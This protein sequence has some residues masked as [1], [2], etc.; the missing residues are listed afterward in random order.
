MFGREGAVPGHEIIGTVVEAG[1][2]S[3]VEVGT[4]VGAGWQTNSCHACG[5]CR[6]GYEQYCSDMTNYFSAPNGGFASHVTWD[7]RHV[8]RIP[9]EL[10][11]VDAA[12]LLCAGATTFSAIADSGVRPGDT[13]GVIGI[14]GLGHIAVQFARAWGCNVV[15]L[16]RSADK[17]EQ[18]IAL[19]AHEVLITTDADAMNRARGSINLLLSTVPGNLDLDMYMKLVAPR[20]STCIVGIAGKPLEVGGS[21]LIMGGRSLS[22]SLIAGSKNME[23]ML[24][25]AVL[26]KV[27]PQVETFPMT[28]EGCAAA[29]AKIHDNTI[30]F[31]AVLVP[32]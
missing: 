23:K 18:A 12:P 2:E 5:V 27:K 3:A 21:S 31:R 19:G 14:G 24:Q 6:D 10:P 4:R 11:S 29:V 16:T 8:F 9:D 28:A 7:S 1:S 22:G 15:A 26:H 20:G 17:T 13:I 25:M 30:R 32:E